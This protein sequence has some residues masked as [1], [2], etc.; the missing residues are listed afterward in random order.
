MHKKFYEKLFECFKQ[1][2]EMASKKYKENEEEVTK[3]NNEND[4][5]EIKGK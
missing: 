3:E 4:D 5:V 2:E 1:E